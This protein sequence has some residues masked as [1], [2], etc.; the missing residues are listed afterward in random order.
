MVEKDEKLATYLALERYRTDNKANTLA[1]KKSALRIMFLRIGQEDPTQGYRVGSVLVGFRRLDDETGTL[2]GS[3]MPVTV[4]QLVYVHNYLLGGLRGGGGV[5]A[6]MM[7]G[8]FFLL[9]VSN[10]AA[11]TGTAYEEKYILLRRD[12]K[13]YTHADVDGSEV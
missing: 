11:P 7:V 2:T 9:R 3:K 8:F 12:V 6:G 13:Y 1:S 5:W 10:M 4:K